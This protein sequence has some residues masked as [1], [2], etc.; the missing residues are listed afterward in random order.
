[1]ADFLLLIEELL[2]HVSI[3]LKADLAPENASFRFSKAV[4][5]FLEASYGLKSQF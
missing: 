2:A 5:G 1:M 3:G 4:C